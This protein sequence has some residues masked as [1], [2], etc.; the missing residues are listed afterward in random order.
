MAGLR[1]NI[2]VS[3]QIVFATLLLER[4]YKRIEL[5]EL[6]L[7]GLPICCGQLITRRSGLLC[8]YRDTRQRKS[9]KEGSEGAWGS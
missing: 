3:D 9:Q 5:I 2:D 6:C 8:K 4:A 1:V 7:Q